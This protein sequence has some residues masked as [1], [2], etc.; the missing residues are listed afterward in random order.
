MRGEG[1]GIAGAAGLV[2]GRGQSGQRIVSF[3]PVDHPNDDAGHGDHQH[4]GQASDA[5]FPI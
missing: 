3:M 5:N 2:N 1:Q 4:D